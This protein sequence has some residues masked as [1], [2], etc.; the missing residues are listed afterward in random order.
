MG[1]RGRNMILLAAAGVIL[2]S[3]AGAGFALQKGGARAGR[4]YIEET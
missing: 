2:L 3:S 1:K 4:E